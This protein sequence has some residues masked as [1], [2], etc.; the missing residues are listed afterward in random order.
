MVLAPDVAISTDPL[1][2]D[3]E[4]ARIDAPELRLFVMALFIFFGCV[5][6]C[7]WGPPDSVIGTQ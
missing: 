7:N 6:A 2:V 5:S 3:D 4:G 1:P